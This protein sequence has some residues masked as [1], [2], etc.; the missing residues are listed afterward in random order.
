M[1][2]VS[3]QIV[4]RWEAKNPSG[5]CEQGSHVV[6]LSGE[7]GC[8]AKVP[9]SQ[10]EQFLHTVSCVGVH[11]EA[12]VCPVVMH[13]E[14][15]EHLV[16]FRREHSLSKNSSLLQEAQSL[17][18]ASKYWPH[19]SSMKLPGPHLEHGLQTGALVRVQFTCV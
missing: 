5:H 2:I 6:S 9:A 18:L 8:L 3:R 13:R 19:G 15:F 11:L 12:A 17:H 14:H 7:H 4:Q 1:Q 10:S 16:S